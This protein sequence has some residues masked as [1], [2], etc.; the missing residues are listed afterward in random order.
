[1]PIMGNVNVYDSATTRSVMRNAI[2]N[3][4]YTAE[5]PLQTEWPPSSDYA[6]EPFCT[7]IRIL[8]FS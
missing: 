4:A 6:L 2:L 1:M 8:G 7:G 3:S 5:G